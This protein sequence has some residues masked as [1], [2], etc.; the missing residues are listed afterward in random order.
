MQEK[1][2]SLEVVKSHFQQWRM[3]RT[4]RREKTPPYLWEMVR[5]IID[6]YSMA[7]ITTA[8]GINKY[9]IRDNLKIKPSINFAVA[10][11]DTAFMNT[12]K[13]LPHIKDEQT[14]VIEL[15]RPNGCFL[16]ISSLSFASASA[17]INQFME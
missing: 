12:Q 8:L 7:D 5:Q 2:I 6:H 11:T 4:K 1:T 14:Y 3:T 17:I 15:H 16:K 13:I 10:K 9:Q